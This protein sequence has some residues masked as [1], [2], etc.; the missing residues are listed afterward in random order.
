VAGVGHEI[1]EKPYVHSICRIDIKY[2]KLK[3]SKTRRSI[4][5]AKLVSVADKRG[6]NSVK[7]ISRSIALMDDLLRARASR[8]KAQ[9]YLGYSSSL[10]KTTRM[11]CS[12]L[13]RIRIDTGSAILSRHHNRNRSMSQFPIGGWEKSRSAESILFRQMKRRLTER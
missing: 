2:R 11:Y 3:P 9:Q 5:Y 1:K 13:A 7:M 12:L 6:G 8:L 10:V 4:E